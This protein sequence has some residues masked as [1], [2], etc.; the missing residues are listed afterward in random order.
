MF[1]GGKRLT[2]F[3]VIFSTAFVSVANVF[4]P[5]TH[6][7]PPPGPEVQTSTYLDTN[8]DGA[9]DII[10]WDFGSDIGT[11]DYE[12]GDWTV[13]TASEMNITITGLDC[14]EGGGIVAENGYVDILVTAD[15]NE[16]HAATAPVISYEDQGT[17]GDLSLF[18]S[19]DIPDQSMISTDDGAAPVIVSVSPV[20]ST[21]NVAVDA[22]VAITFSEPMVTT[23]D[24]G[25]EFTVN[26]NPGGWSD[27]FSAGNTVATLSHTGDF[28]DDAMITVTLD[29]TEVDAA[30]GSETALNNSASENGIWSFS[31][32]PTVKGHSSGSSA[33]PAPKVYSVD[34][35]APNGGETLYA[36]D[37]KRITWKTADTGWIPV[38]NIDYS[39]DGGETYEGIAT[40]ETNDGTYIWTVPDMTSAQARIR[41]TA[42]DLAAPLAVDE[43][44]MNFTILGSDPLPR[45]IECGAM[46][47]GSSELG[48]SPVT[49]NEE[50]ISS[51]SYGDVIRGVSFDTLY[52]V[53]DNATRRPFI[54][55]Q[56]L[57]T[58]H[59][60]DCALIVTDATLRALP[61]GPP[62]LPKPGSVLIK[63]RADEKVYAV[64]RHPTDSDR[65]LKRLIPS[66]SLASSLIG[67]DWADFVIDVPEPLFKRFDDGPQITS[68]DTFDRKKMVKRA[69]S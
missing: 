22:D 3:L 36:G 53:T 24:Y 47:E 30:A 6:A 1:S 19:S 42:T 25:T 64:D 12:A 28:L 39:V 7:A 33:E 21:V 15:A 41:V 34:V 38:V 66:E 52:M 43:S 16:T 44:D 50:E 8:N 55:E 23:F 14:D 59:E 65:A 48:I 29:G 61:L 62:M 27:A 54:D 31:T 32:G 35:L 56:I 40:A 57:L 49:G 68:A 17:L 18:M 26:P 60:A 45:N 2:V 67:D 46:A 69:G 13:N 51:V 9:I 5:R 4:I 58:W 11:C 37:R 10:R 20:Q 63:W